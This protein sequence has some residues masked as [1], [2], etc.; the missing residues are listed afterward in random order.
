MSEMAANSKGSQGLKKMRNRTGKAP[1][2][3]CSNCKCMRYSPCNCLL[4]K[5]K[6][7]KEEVVA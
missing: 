4:L 3:Q 1:T 5:G 2:Y 6:E 7:R